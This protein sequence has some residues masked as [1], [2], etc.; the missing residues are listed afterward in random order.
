QFE[1]WL[2]SHP[3][4]VWETLRSLFGYWIPPYQVGTLLAHFLFVVGLYLLGTFLT[5]QR[6]VGLTSAGLLAAT[7]IHFDAFRWLTHVI[8]FCWQG[9]LLCLALIAVIWEYRE[10]KGQR[11]PY[12]ATFLVIPAFAAGI[13]RAGIILPVVSLT[14]AMVALPDLGRRTIR[15]WLG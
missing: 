14:D 6:S 7:T 13:A 12:L 8:N 15:P 2:S 5:R 9:L 3:A 4:W 10:G 1:P 11:P